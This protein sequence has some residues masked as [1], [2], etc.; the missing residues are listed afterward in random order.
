MALVNDSFIDANVAEWLR[1][2]AQAICLV[3]VSGVILVG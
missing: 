3:R 2:Q 1:R